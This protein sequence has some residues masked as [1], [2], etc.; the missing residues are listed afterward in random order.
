MA[1]VAESGIDRWFFGG[2]ATHTPESARRLAYTATGGA[3]GT[4]GVSDLTVRPLV[5]PGEGVRVSI[6]SALIRSRFVGGETQTYQAAVYREVLLDIEPNTTNATRY[7]LVILRA[8]DPYAG[9]STWPEP[10]PSD[11]AEEQ[12]IYARVISGV[13]GSVKKVQQVPG[14]AND[15]AITLARIAIPPLTGTITVAEIT[16][17]REVAQPRTLTVVRA[18]NLPTDTLPDRISAGES[19]MEIWP[20]QAQVAGVL[21]VDIPEW[22]TVMKI[23]MTVSSFVAPG[24]GLAHGRFATQVGETSNPN[25][26]VTEVTTWSVAGTSVAYRDSVRN[27]DTRRIPAALRGTTQ[28]FY[29]RANRRAGTLTQGIYAD[30]ATCVDFTVVFQEEAD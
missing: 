9:G 20:Q 21:D 19:S 11:K 16:H 27:S 17:L 10:A 28:R 29:P 5:I 3:E 4:G 1:S 14:R 6:G 13:G 25:R 2:G 22:A 8:E 15:S 12:Y 24:D 23:V 18:Y 30:S 7:D 26:V